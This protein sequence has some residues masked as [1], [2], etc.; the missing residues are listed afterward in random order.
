MFSHVFDGPVQDLTLIELFQMACEIQMILLS[1]F[2]KAFLYGFFLY[3]GSILKKT[4]NLSWRH[5][6]W[7]RL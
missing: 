3:C 2:H 6:S 1:E 7:A 4:S 5:L